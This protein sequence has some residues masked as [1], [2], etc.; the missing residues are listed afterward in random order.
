MK[1]HVVSFQVPFPADYGGAIDV[2]Y[3]L[4]AMKEAGFDIT[5]HTFIYGNRT[6]QP[7][8]GEICSKVYYY[9]RCTGWRKQFSMLPY[10]VN[11]RNHPDLLKNLCT[12]DAPILFEGVHCCYLLTHPALVGRKKIVRMHNVEHE[13]YRRLASQAGWNW[14]SLYYLVESWRLRRF[15][16]RLAQADLVCAI[17]K[18]DKQKF[19]HIAQGTE[20]I[21]LPVFF[22]TKPL[23]ELATA[24]QSSPLNYVLY[25]GNMAVEENMRIARFIVEE[26]APR[27]PGA[28]FIIAGRK[29]QMQKVAANVKVVADPTDEELDELIKGAR[30]HL[31]LTFQ[32]TGIK[33]KLL[34]SLTKG[35]GHIIA[36]H[37]MLYGHSL[38]KFCTRADKTE[39]IEA[40]IKS[41]INSPI[42]KGEFERRLQ[43]LQKIKKAGIS[44]LSLF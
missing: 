32:P 19:D 13:Y 10:I 36:N 29:A 9:P 16:R 8:L 14:K 11:S 41:L 43:Y 2:F 6:E 24:T 1:I 21:H 28:L 20:V 40:A 18:A 38:G 39:E 3:K 37:D 4:K 17:T 31:M 5:L 35:R 22:D 27:C 25:Q 44:R 33:L 12:D 15:E 34:N 30:I 23:E 42:E 26:I 7:V